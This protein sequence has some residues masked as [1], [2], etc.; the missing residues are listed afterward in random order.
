MWEN[1]SVTSA[2]QKVRALVIVAIIA[3]LLIGMFVLFTW[4]TVLS[5]ANNLR[6]PPSTNCAY[7]D[8]MFAGNNATYQTYAETD[9]PFT[10][11]QQGTGIYQCYC[12]A[13]FA[14][15]QYFDLAPTDT[16]YEYAR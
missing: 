14:V 13:N 3:L 12:F 11:N 9:R 7:I 15:S 2:V 16:C 6:Y 1:L 8:A 4:L 5:V 10:V